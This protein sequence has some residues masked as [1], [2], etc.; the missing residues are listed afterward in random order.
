M[1]IEFLWQKNIQEKL[2]TITNQVSYIYIYEKL[3]S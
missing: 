2:L 1:I 3:E